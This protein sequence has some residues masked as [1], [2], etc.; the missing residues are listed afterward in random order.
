VASAHRHRPGLGQRDGHED[1][2]FLE[3]WGDIV[4][5]PARGE[6]GWGITIGVA[7]TD[8]LNAALE[9]AREV[10][11]D[12]LLEQ[13]CE[14]EDLRIVVIDGELVAASVRR[15]PTII[16]DGQRPVAELIVELSDQ[17]EE[18]T[19]GRVTIPLDDVTRSVVRAEAY[20][21]Q[22]V[23]D[24]GV[25]LAVRRTGNVHTGGTIDD[26][27]D[28]LHPGLAAVAVQAAQAS[29]SPL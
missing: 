16:G 12:V 1:A 25:E 7:T 15:P 23:P 14:G 20:D 24:P 5:K 8:Q 2:A 29:K 27:T 4:V 13:R 6:Q 9:A 19:D 11:P 17:R 18:A 10:C 22:S 28:E 21:F 26:V 3:M